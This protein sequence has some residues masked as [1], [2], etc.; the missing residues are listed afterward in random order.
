M[1]A[2]VS[3]MQVSRQQQA[4]SVNWSA[5]AGQAVHCLAASSDGLIAAGC[6]DSV[7]LARPSNAGTDIIRL[8]GSTG[9]CTTICF[10]Q[11]QLVGAGPAGMLWAW[12]RRTGDQQGCVRLWATNAAATAAFNKQHARVLIAPFDEQGLLAVACTSTRC[13]KGH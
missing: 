5:A 7:L 12:H 13:A 10:T 11:D 9:P 6:E 3:V 2:W 1:R 4:L 8:S